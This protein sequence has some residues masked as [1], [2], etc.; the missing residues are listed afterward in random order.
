[1]LNAFALSRSDSSASVTPASGPRAASSRTSSK[2]T[3]YENV[4]TSVITIFV[5]RPN[6]P[7]P[8]AYHLSFVADQPAALVHKQMDGLALLAVFEDC[9]IPPDEFHVTTRPFAVIVI[10]SAS[11]PAIRVAELPSFAPTEEEDDRIV[12]RGADST[13]LLTAETSVNL[14]SASVQAASFKFD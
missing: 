14:G 3:N 8:A 5:R 10:S 11:G 2:G 7:I 6:L 1:V 12:L 4:G 13:L 9:A